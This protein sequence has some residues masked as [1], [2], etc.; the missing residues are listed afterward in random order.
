MTQVGWSERQTRVIADEVRRHRIRLGLSA[1]QLATRCTD[2]G[3]PLSRDVITNLENGRRPAVST[4]ELV[5]LAT[6]LETPPILLIYPLGYATTVETLPGQEVPTWDAVRWFLGDVRL[7]GMPQSD[8][9]TLTELY[10][11]H[12]SRLA[13]VSLA[14]RLADAARRTAASIPADD[15][16]FHQAAEEWEE[17]VKL[18]LQAEGSVREL[19]DRFRAA[20]LLPPPLPDGLAEI[21]EAP[22]DP[23]PVLRFPSRTELLL[24]LRARQTFL[25]AMEEDGK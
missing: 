20:D 21:D 17:A 11:A 16:K 14:R 7:R 13:H 3:H 10:R 25:D 1:Q 22:G 4:T 2:L 19:R 24:R 15:P 23:E 12:E 18:A 6:A 8:E 9:S 5:V